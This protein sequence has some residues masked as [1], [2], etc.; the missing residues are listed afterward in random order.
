VYILGNSV[1]AGASFLFKVFDVSALVSVNSLIA[2]SPGASM[3]VML[4]H[5]LLNVTAGFSTSSQKCFYQVQT[6][7]SSTDLK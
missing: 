5:F 6:L 1:A 4:D 7:S 2:I 3:E